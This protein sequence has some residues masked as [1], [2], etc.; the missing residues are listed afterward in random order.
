MAAEAVWQRGELLVLPM[1]RLVAAWP[2]RMA[3]WIDDPT[4]WAVPLE[5]LLSAAVLGTLVVAVRSRR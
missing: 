3:G 5:M 4:R 1:A 2:D